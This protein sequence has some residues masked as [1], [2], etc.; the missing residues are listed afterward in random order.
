MEFTNYILLTI[1][2]LLI[3]ILIL[4]LKE[5]NIKLS[6]DVKKKKIIGVI[7]RYNEDLKWLNEYPFNQITYIVYNKGINDKF[8]K[9][10]VIKIINLKNVGRCDHTYLYHVVN[11]YDNLDDITIF[12][13]GS[14]DMILKKHI[15]KELI[16]KIIK[17]NIGIMITQPFIKLFEKTLYDFEVNNYSASY[18]KNKDLNPEKKIQKSK[19][20]PFG[21]WYED[22]FNNFDIKYTIQYGIFSI[23][24]KDILQFSKEYYNKFLF[25][26][27]ESSNPEAGH[28]IEKSWV[29][30]FNP[31]YTQKITSN[32]IQFLCIF[33][34][35]F[36]L[37][38]I[39]NNFI[40]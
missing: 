29:S 33:F 8:N 27:S 40:I 24:K 5:N 36:Y 26:V 15:A 9:K 23:D 22:K 16:D 30:I 4:F 31:K 37:H 38:T 35:F 20:R 21:K 2:I 28:Y 39:K 34:D 18:G 32:F 13:P 6:R 10:N 25:D 12:L 7:A 11:N 1:L 19:I 14:V 3:L 17:Y